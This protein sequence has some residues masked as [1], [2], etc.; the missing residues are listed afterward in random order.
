MRARATAG[1]A[2]ALV[3]ILLAACG[4]TAPPATATSHGT[5]TIA[6]SRL[7]PEARQTLKLIDQGGPYPYRQDGAVFGNRERLLPDK[8]S[9]YYHEYTVPTSGGRGARR[10]VTG[11]QSER[12]YSDDHYRSFKE[13]V[14][15]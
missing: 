3:T 2:A 10:V 6:V 4:G 1:G 9:G 8:P 14:P 11:G 15:G 5:A 13:I 7:P 12:Y